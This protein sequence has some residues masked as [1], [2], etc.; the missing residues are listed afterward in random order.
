MNQ[1][2]F[3]SVFVSII[4]ALGISNILSSAMRLIR[5][6]GR[7]RVHHATLVWMASLFL[8]QVLAWWLAFQRRDLTNWTFFR[9]L[10]YLLMPILVS[11]PGYLLV[12]EIE[13]E[14]EPD[15]D[16]AKEF[17]HNRRWFFAML[18]AV[19]VIGFVESVVSSGTW[20]LGLGNAFP[21]MMAV[22]CVAGLLIRAR[23]AQLVIAVTF[24]A[25][26][27][28]YIGLVFSQL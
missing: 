20:R 15:F 24:L 11:V 23:T 9:F 1:F 13:L 8:L 16:L 5:R 22:L 10:L 12:P 19:G 4:I 17:N 14:L 6:R 25:I 18:T 7:V 27:L 28:A 26:L 2:E 21:L 3:L